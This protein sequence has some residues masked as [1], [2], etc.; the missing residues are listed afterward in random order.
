M[1]KLIAVSDDVYSTLYK[2]KGSGDSFSKVIVKTI[3]AYQSRKKDISDLAGVLKDKDVST[4][5]KEVEEGRKRSFKR[6]MTK[7]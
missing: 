2:M 4:W 7:L 3:T 5:L 6:K 1:S